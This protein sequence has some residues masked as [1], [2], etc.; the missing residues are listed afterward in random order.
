MKRILVILAIII[1]LT[2]CRFQQE[3]ITPSK[4]LTYIID[5]AEYNF[6]LHTP[7]IGDHYKL[8]YTKREGEYLKVNVSYTGGCLQHDFNIFWN[9]IFLYSMPASA[10]IL[11][12]HN[13][14]SDACENNLTENIII[15]LK[16][17]FG[18]NYK[19]AL[20]IIIINGY[21]TQI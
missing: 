21:F 14:N 3:V 20:E 5:S 2:A 15:D 1:S 11:I 6:V 19:D 10:T 4:N 9:E 17:I 12:T 7:Q 13:A 8:N 16:Q 18:D